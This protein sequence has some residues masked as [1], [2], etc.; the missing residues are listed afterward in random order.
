MVDVLSTGG[1]IFV[2]KSM[3]MEETANTVW[4]TQRRDWTLKILRTI[5]TQYVYSLKKMFLRGTL[6]TQQKRYEW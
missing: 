2:P 3:K 6:L 4:K 5:H 1:F